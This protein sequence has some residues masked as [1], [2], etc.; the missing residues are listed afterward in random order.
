MALLRWNPFDVMTAWDR[1]VQDMM[2][3]ALARPQTGTRTEWSWQ[4]RSEVFKEDDKLVVR[5][6]LPGVDPQKDVEVELDGNVLRIRGQRSFD[7]EVKEEDVF[8]SERVFGSFTRDLM[9][10]EGI[11]PDQL[12]AA[13]D[14]GVLTVTMPLPSALGPKTRRIPVTNQG[15]ASTAI[16]TGG[17][18]QGE[19]ADSAATADPIS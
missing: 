4:P 15:T 13:Y 3:R 17:T 18:E 11:D 7:R 2:G 16:E 5:V 19:A 8:L 14:S 9:L 12:S 10:P 6:E 1:E